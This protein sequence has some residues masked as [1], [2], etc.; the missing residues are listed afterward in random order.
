MVNREWTRL[1]WHQSEAWCK[2]TNIHLINQLHNIIILSMSLKCLVRSTVNK[3]LAW[4]HIFRSKIPYYLIRKYFLAEILLPF[5]NTI[6]YAWTKVSRNFTNIIYTSCIKRFTIWK[7]ICNIIFHSVSIVI[8]SQVWTR[9][10]IRC[11]REEMREILLV[12][13]KNSIHEHQ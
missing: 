4:Y 13:W 3:I 6:I 11:S 10:R 2:A 1:D 12:N 8:L 7:I 9:L 5:Q